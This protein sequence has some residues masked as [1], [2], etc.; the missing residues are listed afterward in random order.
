MP[1]GG[2]HP[3]EGVFELTSLALEDLAREPEPRRASAYF[4][5]QALTLLGWAPGLAS[6]AVCE[7]PL[8]PEPAGFAAAADGFV[9]AACQAGVPGLL[10]VSPNGLK[11]LRVM[12]AGDISLYRRLRLEGVLL[13]EVEAVLEAQL[14]HHLDRRLKSLQFLRRLR[15]L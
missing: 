15:S 3:V 2:R 9:C 10:P 1:E 7:R 4:L 5:A 12:A 6:C 11:V 14:E 13:E 8:P